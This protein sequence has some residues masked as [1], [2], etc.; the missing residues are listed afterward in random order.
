VR[1]LAAAAAALALAV[2]ALASDP[3]GGTYAGKLRCTENA[4][5]AVGKTKQD[6]EI[7]VLADATTFALGV[8]ASGQTYAYRIEGP[9]IENAAKPERTTL[10]GIDCDY[11]EVETWGIA[12]R[13]EAAIKDGSPKGTMKGTLI[14][15]SG[16]EGRSSELCRFSVKRT[17]TEA[18]VVSACPP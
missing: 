16:V 13:A 11:R 15:Q 4:A 18:P 2:P 14:R 5:G 1:A 17:S 8:Y 7:R 10:A 6:L 9:I 12:F 3:I